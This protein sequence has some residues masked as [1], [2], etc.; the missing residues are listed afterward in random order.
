M[1]V[2]ELQQLRATQHLNSTGPIRPGQGPQTGPTQPGETQPQDGKPFAE[3]LD[4]QLKETEGIRFSAHAVRR[5]DN[6][7]IHL[8]TADVTRLENGVRKMEEKG[9]QSSLLL[10]NDNAYIVSVKNRTVVT[11][12]DVNAAQDNVFTN[13]DSVAIL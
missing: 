9:A 2:A 3:I 1:K 12:L 6:R 13:I 8:S 11:A 5:L 7:G 4:T 10:M